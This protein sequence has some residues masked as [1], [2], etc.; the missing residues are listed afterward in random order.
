[1]KE[2]NKSKAKQNKDRKEQTGDTSYCE[3]VRAKWFCY[4]FKLGFP[5]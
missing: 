1:M 2:K 3:R 4:V 5:Q